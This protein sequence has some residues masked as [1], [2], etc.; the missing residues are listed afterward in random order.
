MHI[1]IFTHPAFTGAHSISKYSQMIAEGMRQRGHYVEVCTA[2]PYL[3]RLPFPVGLKKWLGYIDQ[4]V[5]FPMSFIKQLKKYPKNT[6]FVFADQA[7]GP[8]V[9]LVT[10][11]PHL[12]HCHDFLAQRSALGEIPENKVGLTGKVYQTLIRRG[13]SKGKN[14]ICISQKTQ[15][16]LHRFLGGV[17]PLSRVV[18][19]GLNQD[20]K[21]GNVE[22]ARKKLE[23]GLSLDLKDG[24]ILHVGG[25]Q[26]YKNRK[27]VLQIYNAWR[28]LTKRKLHLIM[29][30]PHPSDNLRKLQGSGIFSEQIHFLA[31]VSDE[32]LKIVYQ[33]ARVLLFPSLEEGFGWPIAEAMA[34]GCPVITT[35]KAPMTEVGG[36]DCIYIPRYPESEG[37]EEKWAIDCAGTLDHILKLSE[38]ARQELI[39][40]GIENALRFNP[41]DTLERIEK[42]YRDVLEGEKVGAFKTKF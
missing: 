30:G 11:R 1:V 14:F 23:I 38:E 32:L 28:E 31:N 40:T 33:G 20:F 12:I 19:N 3:Y 22:M 9:P 26:F 7:L 8:W 25:D 18:Y 13:Y 16:D 39:E 29:I 34:S 41:K 15:T 17:P 5:V 24:Y 4:F 35:N 37:S 36:R 21:P 6:L 27:G 2:N 10:D 42:I